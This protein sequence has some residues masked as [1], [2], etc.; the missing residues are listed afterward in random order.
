MSWLDRSVGTP[1]AQVHDFPQRLFWFVCIC[2]CSWWLRRELL[3]LWS[4]SHMVLGMPNSWPYCIVPSANT[5]VLQCLNSSN[6]SCHDP[7]SATWTH[8]DCKILL[9][10]SFQVFKYEEIYR[11]F[12]CLFWFWWKWV[13]ESGWYI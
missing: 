4:W 9:T 5:L 1:T 2:N 7:C 12:C 11:R 3:G 8:L 13:S 10:Y 6:T